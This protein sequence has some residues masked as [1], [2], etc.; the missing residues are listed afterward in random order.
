V[1]SEP[2]VDKIDVTRPWRDGGRDAVGEYLPGPH[3]D[4]VAVEFALEAKYHAPTNGVGVRE[5]S[6]L[7]SR[8]RHRQFGILVTTSYLDAQAYRE[9]REDGHPV[10]V[11][12]GRDLIERLKTRGL[13][14]ITAVLQHLED[15]Y[16]PHQLGLQAP[17]RT[18]HRRSAPEFV[19]P[20]AV[21]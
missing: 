14:N 15:A 18:R 1:A 9:I 4:P 3:S 12:A 10:V 2:N 13:G 8:L 7:I 19:W 16:L 5:T 20:L 21:S 17:D 6:R 11:L